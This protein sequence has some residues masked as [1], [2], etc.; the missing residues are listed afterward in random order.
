MHLRSV[1]G[2]FVLSTGL[3]VSFGGGAIATADSGSVAPGGTQTTDGTTQSTGTTGTTQTPTTTDPTPAEGET[4]GTGVTGLASQTGVTTA[5]TTD[6][7]SDSDLAKQIINAATPLSNTAEASS[8]PTPTN[9]SPTSEPAVVASDSNVPASDNTG[10]AATSTMATSTS[11]V[12]APVTTTIQQLVN[13]VQQ[14]AANA[15]TS[16]T[17]TIAAAPA[18]VTAPPPT[19]PLAGVI[20][21]VQYILNT[22]VGVV[23]PL[24]QTAGDLYALLGFQSTT[25]PLIGESGVP[26]FTADRGGPLFGPQVAQWTSAVPAAGSGG[27]LFGTMTP[28][29]QPVLGAVAKSS[30]LVQQLSLSGTAPLAPE[31]IRPAD[32]RTLLEHVVSAVLV[33]ASLTALAAFALPGIGGLLVV[34]AFGIRVGYRQAKA[35]LAL[36]ASGIARFAG[37]GPLGVVRSGSLV[38][39][40]TRRPRADRVAA[41][42]PAASQAVVR[43]LERVA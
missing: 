26:T 20:T 34:M 22:V 38:S 23:A 40:H 31:G 18:Q 14:P 41:P 16:A 37:G 36:R 35:G 42:A 6:P 3:I 33:P 1:A 15:I 5:P 19:T 10:P 32:T 9:L 7:A 27:P 12:V 8:T 24:M 39:L 43:H 25:A 30:A 17:N 13:A 21:S 28:P 4:A 29:Q 2:V 11:N